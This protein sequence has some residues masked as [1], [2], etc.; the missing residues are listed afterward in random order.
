MATWSAGGD[1]Y[2]PKTANSDATYVKLKPTDSAASGTA[3]ASG[4]KTYDAAINVDM[5]SIPLLTI[6]QR[7]ESLGKSAGVVS[8]VQI[9]HATPASMA[10]HNVSRNNYSAIAQEMILQTRLD[11]I[12]GAGHPWY[13][14]S[15]DSLNVDSINALSASA[16]AKR[17]Q[18]V[19]GDT[20]WN[21]LR[22]GKASGQEGIWKLIETKE[23]FENFAN[24]EGSTP[25]RLIGIAQAATTL[26]Q[27]RSGGAA[28]DEVGE[29]SFNENVPDLATMSKGALRVLSKNE[30]GFFLMIEGGAVDWAGHANQSARLIEEQMDFNNAVDSVIKWIEAHGGFEENLLI[31]TGDHET[32]YLTGENTTIAA[33]T[34]ARVYPVQNKGEG[35]M[36]GMQWNSGDHTNQLIPL[37][38]KGAGSESIT[39]QA[40]EWD[41]V[42]KYYVRN[43]EVGATM[44]ELWPLP[45]QSEL[46]IPR[47]TFLLLSD[48]CGFNCFQAANYYANGKDTSSYSGWSFMPISTYSAGGN[49]YQ[50]K[51]ANS[52][53]T[54][55]KLK[56]TDSAASGTAFSSGIKTYDAALNVDMDTLD[57]KSIV[58]SVSARGLSTGSITSVQFSHATPASM[59]AH[60]KSRNDYAGIAKEMILSTKLDVII[61]A[62]HP[63]YDDNGDS[64]KVDS[65]NA[66]S[67]SDK[68]KRYQYVG[69]DTLWTNL[70]KGAAKSVDDTAW[71]LVTTKSEFETLANGNRKTAPARLL[72]VAQAATTFQQCRLPASVNDTV[73]EVAFNDNIPNLATITKAAINTLDRNPL[74]FFIMVEGGAVDWAGHANQPGRIVEE[75]HDF[76]IMVDTVIAWIERNNAWNE[77]QVIVVTDHETGYITGPSSIIAADTSARLYPI[78]NS[79]KGK[80]PGMEFHSGNHTN[81]LVP[82]FVKGLNEAFYTQLATEWDPQ[83]GYFGDNAKVGQV[84]Q[85]QYLLG[86]LPTPRV[87][88]Q[89]KTTQKISPL[90]TQLQVVGSLAMLQMSRSDVVR[91]S[92][93]STDGTRLHVLFNGYAQAGTQVF[94][95]PRTTGVAMLVLETSNGKQV[96]NIS[97]IK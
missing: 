96:R 2:A 78:V 35:N 25:A 72:G 50:P 92:L 30:K 54:Y 80:Q 66:L 24:G 47:F 62:G 17:Y 26:Q 29:V 9:S 90:T 94:Q 31:V 51:A 7:A 69:G 10:A 40:D 68:A 76:N 43:N 4:V 18:Y 13:N 82:F 91:L 45:A 65:I 48:G 20:L 32:G 89:V 86:T 1:G 95:I 53:A 41:P 63:W 81:Q 11:V 3:F 88:E 46:K 49:S 36:P 85:M 34:S 52:D 21:N 42:R 6:T 84:M 14:D 38:A 77:S 27:S 44:F 71:H 79:G 39:K 12:M 93:Y 87:D 57:V 5:N 58:E 73:N 60:N 74:G 16:K 33:D 97:N 56:Y 61:G 70:L 83:Y 55:V 15:G 67:A 23:Q 64:L 59:A 19:G 37:F 28:D 22:A 75:Q 8:T